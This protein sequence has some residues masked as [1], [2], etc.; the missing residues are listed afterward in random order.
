MLLF[1]SSF[2]AVF[3]I[4]V[5]VANVAVSADKEVLLFN[6]KDL[7]GWTHHSRDPDSK[8][9]DVWQVEDGILVCTGMPVGYLRT[10]KVD[11]E[12][13]T[14]T[15]DWRWKPGTKGG[16]SGVLIH[17]S[18]PNALGVW[19]KSLEV[20]LGS[21]NAGDFWAI[22]LDT[23]FDVVNEDQRRKGRRVLNLTDDSEKPIGEW[24]KMEITC[25][26]DEII[27]R[28]NGDLVN[29]ATNCSVQK[30]AICLQS[31]GAP[32]HFRNIVLRPLAG[33]E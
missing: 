22:P 4:H 32:I 24:N 31:E 1:R 13:Y 11:Y 26:N 7:T 25:K 15:L 6:G 30:G 28:V 20:Q 3:A 27:V 10:V 33:T 9:A 16:N 19:P 12:N 18:T 2:L 23:D 8:I 5:T 17:T 14:L 29:H 21:G